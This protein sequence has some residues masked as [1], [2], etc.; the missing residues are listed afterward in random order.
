MAVLLVAQARAQ[1][2]RG[3]TEL[4]QKTKAFGEQLKSWRAEFTQTSQMLGPG[5]NLKDEVRTKIASQPPLK[6]SR[7]NSGDDR[8]T[9]VCDGVNFFYSGDAHSYYKDEANQQCNLPLIALYEPSLEQL[10][11]PSNSVVSLSVIGEDHVRLTDGERRCVVI[12]AEL[13]RGPVHTVR[14]MCI[15]PAR[16]T[17]LRDIVEAENQANGL[18]SSTTTTLTSFEVNADISPDTF[19][20]T[21]PPGAVEAHPPN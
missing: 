15:D 11:E 4:L 3:A 18:K 14:R 8:T 13:K 19:R 10:L 9:M 2:S 6:M 16:P 20:F 12:R 1:N 17:I 7:V 5:L 21:V